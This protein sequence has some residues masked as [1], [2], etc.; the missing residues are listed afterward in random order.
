MFLSQLRK[1]QWNLKYG[2]TANLLFFFTRLRSPQRNLKSENA[3]NRLVRSHLRKPQWNLTCGTTKN[4]FVFYSF[5]VTPTEPPIGKC[6]KPIGCLPIRGNLNGSSNVELLKTYWFFTH[7]R[8]HQRNL[9]SENG[10]SL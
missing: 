4:L 1:P 6:Y 9:K 7:L 5:E 8:S 2:I 10:I 3:I